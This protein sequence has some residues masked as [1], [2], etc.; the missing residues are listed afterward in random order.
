M[1]V[2]LVTNGKLYSKGSIMRRLL[3]VATASTY[4]RLH[5]AYA[6]SVQTYMDFV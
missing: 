1:Q 6:G 4:K 5:F 3:C 2:P